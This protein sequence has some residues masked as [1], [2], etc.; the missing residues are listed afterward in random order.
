MS[1]RMRLLLSGVIVSKQFTTKQLFKEMYRVA[2]RF[3]SDK[4]GYPLLAD[5]KR[6]EQRFMINEDSSELISRLFIHA[7]RA[8]DARE[9]CDRLVV[10]SELR[11]LI[12][13]EGLPF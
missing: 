7:K 13:F 10:K 5:I 4:Y 9:Q 12:H 3:E 6:I 1:L 8:L 11:K 2:R